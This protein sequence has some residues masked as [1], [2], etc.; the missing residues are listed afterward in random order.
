MG[1]SLTKS[2]NLS[3]LIQSPTTASL[4][5]ENLDHCGVTLFRSQGEENLR[6]VEDETV[7]P[8]KK[9][10]NPS[11]VCCVP[12]CTNSD[13]LKL[14]HCSICSSNV[15]CRSH[16]DTFDPY[17]CDDTFGSCTSLAKDYEGVWWTNDATFCGEKLCHDCYHLDKQ[18]PNPKDLNKIWPF[19]YP[20]GKFRIV[21]ECCGYMQDPYYLEKYGLQMHEVGLK[22]PH[23]IQCSCCQY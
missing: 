9:Q 15:I 12:S 6:K 21:T 14:V 13:P 20:E 8:E 19:T 17:E 7:E 1:T 4:P 23:S 16:L 10:E 18:K 11:A 2:E 5:I 22:T 3:I